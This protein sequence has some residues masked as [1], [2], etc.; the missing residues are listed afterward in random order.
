MTHLFKNNAINIAHK[1]AL[2]CQLVAVKNCVVISRINRKVFVLI[3]CLHS[4]RDVLY[5]DRIR[6]II[7][8]QSTNT[9]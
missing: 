1:N 4:V 8:I 6:F 5:G 2:I 9:L 3:K 7:T